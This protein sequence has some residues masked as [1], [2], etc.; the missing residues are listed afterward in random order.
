MIRLI[1]GATLSMF[2]GA[3]A[4]AQQPIV[5]GQTIATTGSLAEHGRGLVLGARAHFAQVNGAGGIRGRAIELRT[6]DDGGDGAR[7]AANTGTL[8]SDPAVLVIFSGA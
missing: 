8:A 3:G 4:V 5:I 6:L 7:A 1:V 2:L